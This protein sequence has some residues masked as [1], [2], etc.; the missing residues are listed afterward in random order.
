MFPPEKLGLI[1]VSAFPNLN[2]FKKHAKDIAWDTEAW[3]ADMPDHL[4]HFNGD[5][6]VG[7][8]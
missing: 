6:F 2:E 1:F 7:P 3:L 4:I 8:R 5:R